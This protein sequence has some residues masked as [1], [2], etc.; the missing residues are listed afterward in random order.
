MRS[1][2]T[3]G[4]VNTFGAAAVCSLLAVVPVAHAA[5]PWL[6]IEI[7]DA[8]IPGTSGGARI[9]D[10][11]PG[12]PCADPAARI[13]PG[14]IVT[15]INGRPVA[16]KDAL[17]REVRTLQIG[18]RARLTL[19]SP[20]GKTREAS[21]LLTPRKSAD[22]LRAE[23]VGRPAPD[24]APLVLT[25]PALAT[26]ADGKPVSI[27][28][29]RGTPLVLDF[30]ATWCGPCIQST[31]YISELQKRHP[32]VRFVGLSY[33]DPGLIRSFVQQIGPTHTIAYDPDKRG[34]RAFRITAF[35]TMVL[36]DRA[37]NV[38]QIHNEALGDDLETEVAQL[39]SAGL[40]RKSPDAQLR[41]Q[42][43][44]QPRPVPVPVPVP[45]GSV[46]PRPVPASNPRA[47]AGKIPQR[48]APLEAPGATL[49]QPIL[50]QD[51]ELTPVP[52]Q[53]PRGAKPGPRALPVQ[54][55]VM[56]N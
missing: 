55:E 26:A 25:G 33:E 31:P 29:L 42:P 3:R 38:R 14:E 1:T 51:G 5:P 47:T 2:R 52:P 50:G 30:F 39:E 48:H 53:Q 7:E 28:G 49:P 4:I 40:D 45:G 12:A 18:Q 10:I 24:F 34:H 46:Q 8:A 11:V 19:R 6:G 13:Q 17:V 32:G 44:Q 20:A 37:G 16:G 9:T 22:E 21:V 27:A 35:P 15:A 36:I 23:L 41:E 43:A 54:P 56:R